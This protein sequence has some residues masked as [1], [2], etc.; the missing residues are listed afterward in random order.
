M[1][2]PR[3]VM[4][5]FMVMILMLMSQLAPAATKDAETGKNAYFG[6]LHVHT[7]YSYDAFTF[8]TYSSPD[9]AYRFA[10]GEPLAHPAGF[11]LRLEQPLDCKRRLRSE[12]VV[13][14]VEK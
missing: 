13:G 7:R 8:S 4:R 9:D 10:K 1:P 5:T 3:V 14:A 6:N 11:E 12:A 2:E